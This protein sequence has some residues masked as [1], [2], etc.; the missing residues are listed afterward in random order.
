MSSTSNVQS[1]L[2]YVFR[3][4][5]T[6][7]G[8]N[9]STTFNISNV[10][11]IT[12]NTATF[13]RM[14]IGDSNQNVYVGSNSGNAP[15][16]ATAFVTYYNT[17][18]GTSAAA[19][20]S[21]ASNS[22]FFGYLAGNSGKAVYNT[23]IV[24]MNAG[25]LSGT[26]SISNITNSILIGTSNSTGLSNVSNTI[27]IG[28]NAGGG[29][30]SNIFI[31]TSNGIGAA[32]S[33]NIVIGSGSGSNMSGT[34]N[35]IV[36][37]GVYPAII[38][39]YYVNPSNC[40]VSTPTNMSNK[41]FLGS[42]S[43]IIAAGDFS[44]KVFVVG[45][46][47][48]NAYFLGTTT[49]FINSNLYPLSLDVYNYARFE[50]GIGVGKDPSSYALDLNGQINASDGFGVFT[51]SNTNSGT[52]GQSNSSVEI[53]PLNIVAGNTTTNQMTLKLAGNMTLTAANGLPGNITAPGTITGSNVV[54][55]NEV[56]ATGYSSIQSTGL[57]VI[58]NSNSAKALVSVAGNGTI[59]TYTTS[60]SHGFATSNWV[61]IPTGTLDAQGFTNITAQIISNGLT[62]FTIPNS[63]VLTTTS[64]TSNATVVAYPLLSFP[65]TKSGL[66]VGTV[67]DT[68]LTGSNYQT[69][70][71]IIRSPTNAGCNVAAA[72]TT[73]AGSTLTYNL[74]NISN[75]TIIGLSNISAGALTVAYN[76]TYYPT[77]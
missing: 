54:A 19:G 23:I 68:A 51:M 9:F 29:G 67:Y 18:V 73:G 56:V 77:S 2:P 20:I 60:A 14:N 1:Y 47:N 31:G 45:S 4:V 41:F 61:N 33:S 65:I 74:T 58:P 39:T 76:F 42:G 32:G 12:V 13:G 17:A 52:L 21:N 64:I 46:T 6:W 7:T 55:T 22:E 70:N 63:N 72:S 48:T 36:G 25:G 40:N 57:L 44:N 35:V 59:A 24:G 62:T 34:G 8:S 53:K 5:Y 50:R 30:S 75:Q 37:N 49:P 27:S 66:L 26:N 16:N 15:S 69:A 28:G 3:P 10:D 38:P 11:T 71:Y 43:N